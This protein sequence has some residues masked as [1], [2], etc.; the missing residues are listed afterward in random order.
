MWNTL[1]CY[2]NALFLFW[3]VT[4]CIFEFIVRLHIVCIFLSYDCINCDFLI[5]LSIL[6]TKVAKSYQH[7]EKYVET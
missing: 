7:V 1:I 3:N 4:L 2:K 6:L 5:C